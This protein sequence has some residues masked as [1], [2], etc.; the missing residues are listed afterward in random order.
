MFIWHIW[1]FYALLLSQF[2]YLQLQLQLKATP[3]ANKQIQQ[4]TKTVQKLL[5]FDNIVTDDILL[6]WQKK[7]VSYFWFY[8]TYLSLGHTNK[9]IE[10]CN[11]FK[12]SLTQPRLTRLTDWEIERD[13][14]VKIE[15]QI[16]LVGGTM[17][18][19]TGFSIIS[20]IKIIYF[21]INIFFKST[22]GTND[23]T[24]L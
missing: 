23:K 10:P 19:F 6:Q 12:S 8:S 11:W 24:T 14:K 9:K 18:F 17:G 16:S 20:G 13:V 2:H 15:N 22:K 4:Q 1:P 3:A 21:A 5:T 7:L